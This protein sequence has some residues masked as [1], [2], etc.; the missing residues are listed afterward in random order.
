[1]RG[2][3]FACNEERCRETC[4]RGKEKT[5]ERKRATETDRKGNIRE[6]DIWKVG[7]VLQTDWLCEYLG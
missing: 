3:S 2:I 5:R 1:M 7:K 6:M 4:T